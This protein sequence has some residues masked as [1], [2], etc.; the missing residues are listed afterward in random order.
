LNHPPHTHIASKG[1]LSAYAV[2]LLKDMLKDII[3]QDVH[4]DLEE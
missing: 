3:A 2:A 1:A 4:L